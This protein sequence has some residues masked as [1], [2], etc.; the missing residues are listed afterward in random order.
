MEVVQAFF[1]TSLAIFRV[2]GHFEVKDKTGTCRVGVTAGLGSDGVHRKDGHP[3][4]REEV[5]ERD[6]GPRLPKRT[7]SN[8][9][10]RLTS[11]SSIIGPGKEWQG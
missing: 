9:H 6:R 1:F 5:P 3:V 8:I 10:R 11:T 7:N 2:G 4:P